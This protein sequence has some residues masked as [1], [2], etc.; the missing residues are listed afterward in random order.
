MS[1]ETQSTSVLIAGGGP[2]GMVLAIELGGRGIDCILVNEHP[3][4]A[5]HPKANAISSR[6]MEH[7]RRLGVSAP[8]RASGLDD[9]HPTDVAYFTRLD[10]YE[11]GRLEQPGRREALREARQGSGAWASPE[12]PHRSSQIFLERA[13]K[14]K[15][16]SLASVDCRFGCRLE[17]FSETR[18]GIR[19]R[20][21]EV[22]TGREAFVTARYLVGCDGPGSIVRKSQSIEYE[23]GSGIVRPMFGGPM[24]AT[25]FEVTEDLSWLPERRAWQYWIVN[26]DIRA[27]LIH[28]DSTSRFLLHFAIHDARERAAPDPRAFIH[29]AVGREL[30]LSIISTANWTGGFSLVAQRYRAGNVFIAGDAAHLFTPTGGMGMNTG[31]DDAVNLGWKLAAAINGWAGDFLLDSYEAERR[32]IG[33]RNVGFARAFADSVGMVEVSRGIAADTPAG[34]AERIAKTAYHSDHAYREFIIPGVF[35]GLSYVGSPIV[36]DDGSRPPPDHPNRYQPNACPGARAPH[37]WHAGRAVFDAFGPEYTLLDLRGDR[38]LAEV[39]DTLAR[40][41]DIPLSVRAI[42]DD[43]VRALYGRDMVLIRPDHHVAW[44]GDAPPGDTRALL[45]KVAGFGDHGVGASPGRM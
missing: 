27:V 43:A 31:V 35:L 13:L 6:S 39:F 22:A 15:M 25:Y 11:I 41:L 3:E 23:G 24:F 26:P 37:A 14:K 32:P 4:T 12:P 34:A 33:I 1:A 42:Q 9:E 20:L 19:A 7:F 8:I 2:V 28:V 30:P 5:L 40:E 10:G 38:N 21:C 17:N 36:A 18:E 44:R 45:R 29:K 16:D